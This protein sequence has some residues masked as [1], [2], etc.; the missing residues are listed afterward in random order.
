VRCSRAGALDEVVLA[1]DLAAFLVALRRMPAADGPAAGPLT[2]YRGAPL[3][4]YA[5]D[6]RR[7]FGLLDPGTGAGRH[8]FSMRRWSA[9]GIANRCGSTVTSPS[10]TCSSGTDGCPRC[11]TSVAPASATRPAT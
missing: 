5:D 9:G 10:T 11:W 1:E 8:A 7:A 3:E 6:A 4:H 2:A